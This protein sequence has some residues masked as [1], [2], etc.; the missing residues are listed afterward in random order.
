MKKIE[1]NLKNVQKCGK[2]EAFERLG[3]RERQRT[4]ETEEES[5]EK[6][7]EGRVRLRPV[8]DCGL[9]LLL[10]QHSQPTGLA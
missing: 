1:N 5:R 9:G 4:R 6:V 3:E 8:V 7:K 10:P 2:R